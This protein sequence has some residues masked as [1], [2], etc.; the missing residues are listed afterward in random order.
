MAA[1]KPVRLDVDWCTG[2]QYVQNNNTVLNVYTLYETSENE[3]DYL[4][5]LVLISHLF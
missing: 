4:G 3:E 2:I 5:R 1:I